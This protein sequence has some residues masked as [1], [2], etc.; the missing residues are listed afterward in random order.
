LPTETVR[1][2]LIIFSWFSLFACTTGNL[3][4]SLPAIIHDNVSKGGSIPDEIRAG[5]WITYWDF[6]RGMDVIHHKPAL[7]DD[8]FFFAVHL[9]SDGM[10]ILVADPPHNY[11]EA[12]EQVK[13]QKSA[14]WMT[15]VN[16][17]QQ[18]GTSGFIL[19]DSQ[20]LHTIFYQ[21]DKRRTHRERIVELA[22]RYRFSGVDIDYEN[23]PVADREIFTV[24]INEL[25]FDLRQKGISI[26]VTVQ[27]KSRENLSVGPGGANWKELCQS[28]DRLQIMLYNLHSTKTGPGPLA[29]P[30]WMQSVLQF[31][32]G[33]CKDQQIVPV[34]KVSGM[35]WGIQGANGMQYDQIMMLAE[36]YKANIMRDPN[37][38]IPYFSYRA[39]GGEAYT[40]YYEDLQSLKKKIETIYAL[41]L[42]SI[43]FWSLGR[44]DPG[45]LTYLENLTPFNLKDTGMD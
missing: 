19:K 16:D 45:L 26:S 12:V 33:E 17:L 14:A 1:F 18:S 39:E 29:T 20:R 7:M 10:P 3:R 32:K 6:Q 42:R 4:A 43:L 23:L 15:V 22:T 28:V 37:G 13:A 34:I 44:Q 27:P 38:D 36:K 8:V 41:D 24:F 35:Q 2:I 21:A 5:G 40:V 11:Q 9:D 25:A 30:E 31:A